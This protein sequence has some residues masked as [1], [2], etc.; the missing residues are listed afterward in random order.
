M[1]GA[2]ADILSVF[3]LREIDSYGCQ[4]VEAFER[5]CRFVQRLKTFD[6]SA[7][8]ERF[9]HIAY[10]VWLFPEGRELI[11]SL[12]VGAGIDRCAFV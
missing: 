10:A 2:I 7:G 1:I 12:L 8:K 9:C 6:A 11:V 4:L 3:V 5:S